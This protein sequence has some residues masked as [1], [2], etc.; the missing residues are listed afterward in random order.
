MDRG[1]RSTESLRNAGVSLWWLKDVRGACTAL[2]LRLPLP[3]GHNGIVAQK[4]L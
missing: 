3:P 2:V 4:A 1:F